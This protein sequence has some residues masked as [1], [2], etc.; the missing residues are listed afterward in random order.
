MR[1]TKDA[2]NFLQNSWPTGAQRALEAESLSQEGLDGIADFLREGHFAGPIF[3]DGDLYPD[4]N[5]PAHYTVGG[6]EAINVIKAKLTPE[7]FIGYCKGSGLKY[8][9]RANYKGRHDQDILKAEYYMTRAK[10]TIEESKGGA[11]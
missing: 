5:S 9:M 11:A 6:I 8:L 4:V 3:E 7:E 1:F 2:I 10:E